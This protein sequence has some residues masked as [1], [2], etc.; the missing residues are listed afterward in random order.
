LVVSDH[1]FSTI[2][3]GP[4]V[5]EILKKAGFQATKKFDDPEPGDILVVGLGGS[6]S[7]YA[8]DDDERT[9]R[10]LVEFLQ[11]TDFAGEIFSRLPLEGTFP[12]ERV[13]ISTSN[14]A[15]DVLISLRWT[16]ENNENGAPGLF[17]AEGGKKGKGSHASLGPSD[18]RNTLVAAGPDF[19]QGMIDELP[20]GNAD[21]A[22]TILHLLGVPQPAATPM[23]GRVLREALVGSTPSD[24]APATKTLEATHDIGLFR[25]PVP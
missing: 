9:V 10:R 4:D 11:G 16:W 24:D 8:V 5:V 17:L 12:L 7:F 19:K 15:P 18:L 6:V 22:P 3:K 2:S 20:S 1:G 21:L 13:G 23:D 14:G 25:W